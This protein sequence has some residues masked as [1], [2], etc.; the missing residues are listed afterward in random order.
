MPVIAGL[1]RY[2]AAPKEAHIAPPRPTSDPILPVIE[3]H[4]AVERW[5]VARLRD[6]RDL[7]F[8]R[9][10]AVL[11]AVVM[12]V[13]A[14]F[15]LGVLPLW[16][17]PVWVLLMFQQ[18]AGRFTLML[19][20]V[21]HRP[22]FKREHGWME[23]YIPWVLGPFFGHTPGSFYVHHVGMHHPENNLA[24]DL[25]STMGYRRDEV[26]QFV[27]YWARFFFVGTLHLYRYLSHRRR[28][29]LARRFVRGELSW[30][31]GVAA[32]LLLAPGPTLVVFVLPF[33]LIRVFMMTG[34]WAQHAFVAPDRPDDACG[35]STCLINVPY[36]H[37][38][39]NDGYHVVHH[40]KATLHWTEMAKWYQDH[41]DELGARDAL[42]FDG[43][44]NNQ[45][46]W[47]C[48]MTQQWDKLASHVVDL[49]G[50]P[51]RDHAAKVAWL[52][53]R[54]RTPIGV[55][56]GVLELAPAPAG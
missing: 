34:N 35:N 26:G 37:K 55:P 50:A 49:P 16:L 23:A 27:H 12:S 40:I 41:L 33:L 3:P 8:V 48:L 15:A 56:R 52:Q 1:I 31:V 4:N 29:A 36:N 47:W 43:L 30:L 11:S 10:S 46:V 24:E 32:L 22:L 17:G 18:M 7:H 25:S 42:V 21:C 20:A 28:D 38:C 19:H 9:V 45:T 39:Y 54:V 53:E 5:F 14:L 2:R 13:G 6:P 51:V 44:G